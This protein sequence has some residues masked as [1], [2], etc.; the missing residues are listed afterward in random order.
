[1]LISNKKKCRRAEVDQRRGSLAIKKLKIIIIFEI[2]NGTIEVDIVMRIDDKN[3]I[4]NIIVNLIR[5]KEVPHLKV[6]L[7]LL[8]QAQNQVLLHEM[9]L[10]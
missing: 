5:K 6:A 9:I 2:T 10:S 8:N 7:H 3:K 4:L 1:M